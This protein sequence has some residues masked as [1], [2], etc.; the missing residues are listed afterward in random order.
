MSSAHQ[1]VCACEA[2]SY[3]G[4]PQQPILELAAKTKQAPTLVGACGKVVRI[5]GLAAATEHEGHNAQTQQSE[6]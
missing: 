5:R 6:R 4:F 3:S 1:G 2:L